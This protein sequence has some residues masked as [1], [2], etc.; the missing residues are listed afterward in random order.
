VPVCTR[1]GLKFYFYAL[2]AHFGQWL[3]DAATGK[4]KWRVALE[5]LYGQVI[6]AYRRRKLA[7]VER[8]RSVQLG[9]REDSQQAL[10][11]L[12]FTG[13]INTAFIERLNL[14]SPLAAT[15]WPP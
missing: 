11:Q 10:Q 5:L 3:T 15:I 13:S 12:G 7:K 9:Q 2:T 4:P 8:P 1:D 6:K 14:T